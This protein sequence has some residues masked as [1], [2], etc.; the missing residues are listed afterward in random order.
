[1]VIKSST[2]F[3]ESMTKTNIQATKNTQLE[4]IKVLT[5]E[6]LFMGAREVVIKHTGEDY[7]LRLTNQ[8]KL[9]L[10]K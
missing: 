7:R 8:G 4:A 3:C 5:S 9:I 6:D 10:T 2:E 1:M